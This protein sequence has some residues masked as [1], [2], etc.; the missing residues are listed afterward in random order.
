M[1]LAQYLGMFRPRG[2]ALAFDRTDRLLTEL[3]PFFD[4]EIVTRNGVTR[5]CPLAVWQQAL[6]RMIEQR[7]AEKLQ[8]PLKTHGY[9]FEIAFALADSIDAKQER[10]TEASRRRGESRADGERRMQRIEVTY[11]ITSDLKLGL[12][13]I[14]EAERRLKEAGVAPQDVVRILA[15][16]EGSLADE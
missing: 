13:S 10:D 6:E 7:N 8:L 5:A 12:I 15:I 16:K 1:A 14:S 2:R 9:L 3:Q 11:R 4:R